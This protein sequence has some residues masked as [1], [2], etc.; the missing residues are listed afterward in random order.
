MNSRS[1]KLKLAFDSCSLITAAKFKVD[2]KLILDYMLE[3][4]EIHIPDEVRLETTKEYKKYEDARIIKKESMMVKL[5]LI[6]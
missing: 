4:A 6:K 5:L 1:K 2:D 3:I